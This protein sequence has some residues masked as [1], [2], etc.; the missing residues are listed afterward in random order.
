MKNESI[1]WGVVLVLLGGL[2]LLENMGLLPAGVNIWSIFWPLILIAIG[3]RMLLRSSGRGT[4]IGGPASAAAAPGMVCDDRMAPTN[5]KA[6][7][8][9]LPLEGARSARVHIRH[10]AGELRIDDQAGPDELLS[11]LFAGGV[12]PRVSHDGDQLIAEL[13]VPTTNFPVMGADSPLNWTVGFNPNIPLALELQVGASRNRIDLR[14]LQVKELRLE[15]GASET[16]IQMPARAGQTVA[17]LKS[18]MARVEVT[19]PDSVSARIHTSGALSS[20]NVNTAR[21][22]QTST[23][24]YMSPDYEVSA[25]RIDLE[26]ESG[27]GAVQVR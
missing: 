9:R 27:M 13:S 17:R 2:L 14:G 20:L 1:F 21:F 25:N 12:E 3:L 26:I 4:L 24:D 10:G 22:P 16:D 19:I 6:D 8:Y 11:G 15:T 18:G 5:L 7:A 23:S